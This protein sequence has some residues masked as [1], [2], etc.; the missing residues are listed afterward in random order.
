MWGFDSFEGFPK[1]SDKD[2]EA[3][4][5]SGRPSYAKY[6]TLDHVLNN[7]K[8]SGLS[9]DEIDSI[10]LIKGWIPNSFYNYDNSSIS[11]LN[12]DVDLYQSTKDCLNKFW[13]HIC[14][15]EEL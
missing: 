15:L 10:K 5:V 12:I 13:Q 3:F 6:T 11:L 7:C 4:R 1:G 14:H 2:S 9:N 8:K